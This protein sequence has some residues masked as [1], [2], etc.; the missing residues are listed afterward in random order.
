MNSPGLDA[1]RYGLEQGYSE[2]YTM[3]ETQLQPV[4]DDAQYAPAPGL[5]PSNGVAP[6]TSNPF[7]QQQYARASTNPFARQ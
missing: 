2:D 5:P 3:K 7:T 6:Q 1:N 4:V